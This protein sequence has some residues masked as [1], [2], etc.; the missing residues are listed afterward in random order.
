ML[1]LSI[2]LIMLLLG[3]WKKIHVDDKAMIVS[4][5][6]VEIL[7]EIFFFPWEALRSWVS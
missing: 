2:V 5:V 1:C 7:A 4:C 6:A 3:E